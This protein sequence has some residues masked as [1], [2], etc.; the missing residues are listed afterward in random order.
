MIG[1]AGFTPQGLSLETSGRRNASP[2]EPG[3][4]R[5][6]A[7][8][9]TSSGPNPAASGGV[10]LGLRLFVVVFFRFTDK[11]GSVP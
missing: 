5:R 11:S 1:R 7:L 10:A 6:R 2:L 4:G 9:Y 3:G 8:S